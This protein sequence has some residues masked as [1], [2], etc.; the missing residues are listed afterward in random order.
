VNALLTALQKS[1]CLLTYLLTYLGLLGMQTDHIMSADRSQ[2]VCTRYVV[3]LSKDT[4]E[5][6]LG[7]AGCSCS[8]CKTVSPS[9]KNF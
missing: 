1:C 6:S 3:G 2:P 9:L 8:W 5:V 4:R 7:L